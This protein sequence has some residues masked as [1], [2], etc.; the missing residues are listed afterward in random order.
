M[1]V[2]TWGGHGLRDTTL[3]LLLHMLFFTLLLLPHN[4][5]V[6]GLAVVGILPAKQHGQFRACEMAKG[7]YIYKLASIYCKTSM[8]GVTK[9]VQDPQA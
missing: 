5:E 7:H 6:L 4:N 9:N 1:K 3:N 8:H 2:C